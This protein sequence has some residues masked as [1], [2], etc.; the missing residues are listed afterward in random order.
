MKRVYFLFLTA[1]MVVATSC[2]STKPTVSTGSTEMTEGTDVILYAEA[3]PDRRAYGVG[4][5]FKEETARRA[6]EANARA[7]LAAAIQTMVIQSFDSYT[8]SISVASTE[9]GVGG[10]LAEDQVSALNDAVT[11]ISKEC[12]TNTAAVKMQ[13]Y[14]INGQVKVY[15][16]VE[17][18]LAM[19]EL[20]KEVSEKISL[21][22]PDEI[23]ES[24]KY[25]Q[26]LH[27]KKMEEAFNDYTSVS[28]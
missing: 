15:V 19:K 10:V 23:K 22:I 16:C 20:I 11:T 1:L 27:E 13:R 6:A 17:H 18:R 24:L 5:H 12:V 25:D 21:S 2:G 28:K 4:S 14:N 7:A 9:N 8:N 26:Y 3:D